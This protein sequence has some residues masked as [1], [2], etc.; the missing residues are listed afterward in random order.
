MFLPCYMQL[1]FCRVFF[2][3]RH[4]T[5]CSESERKVNVEEGGQ[6]WQHAVFIR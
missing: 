2:E 5:V 1:G 3:L 6:S 4:T